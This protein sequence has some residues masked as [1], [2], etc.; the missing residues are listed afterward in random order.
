VRLKASQFGCHL[1]GAYY[2]CLVYANDILLL[3]QSVQTMQYMLD[4]CDSY[5]IDCDVKFN[6]EKSAA[7]RISPRH[8]Y[9]C[10]ELTLSGKPL[11]YVTSI[12]FSITIAN[13]IFSVTV[14]ILI[15]YCDQFVEPGIRHSRCHCS[16]CEQ[17]TWYS[18]TSTIF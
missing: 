4:I 13:K 1:N 10:A 3:S 9:S 18:A 2:G 12:K 8:C 16:V 11:V 15:Y 7:L 14:L 6:C 5:A 17:T